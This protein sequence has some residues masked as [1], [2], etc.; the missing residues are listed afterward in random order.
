M[1]IEI[2]EK[3]FREI[4][5]KIGDIRAMAITGKMTQRDGCI[6]R[7]G[8]ITAWANEI[9]AL[10]NKGNLTPKAETTKFI[11]RYSTWIC[12]KCGYERDA[13]LWPDML[14]IKDKDIFLMCPGCGH[15]II[16]MVPLVREGG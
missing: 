6:A 3:D 11:E 5:D 1:I 9:T 12:E 15:E 2:D 10:L 8:N 16:E 14:D 13:N 7:L 4:Q